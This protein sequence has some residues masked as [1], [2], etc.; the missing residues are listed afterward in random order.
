[1]D[2][3]L[4]LKAIMAFRGVASSLDAFWSFAGAAS[5]KLRRIIGVLT[6]LRL[7]GAPYDMCGEL[8][9]VIVVYTSTRPSHER[10]MS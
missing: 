6:V 9:W 1:M 7:V 3:S 8:A 4:A 10:L 5:A 2:F